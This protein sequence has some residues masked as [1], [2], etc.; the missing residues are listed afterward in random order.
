VKIEIVPVAESIS[1]PIVVEQAERGGLGG[2]PA[3]RSVDLDRRLTTGA[4][5]DQC[6]IVQDRPLSHAIHSFQN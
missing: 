1:S 2:F 6:K 5:R 3:A 4:S